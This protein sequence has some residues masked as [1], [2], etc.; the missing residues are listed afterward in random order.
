MFR[1]LA[2]KTIEYYWNTV[3]E[4]N[5]RVCLYKTSCSRFVYAEIEKN[6]FIAG[7]K[8]YIFRVRNCNYQYV[9]NSNNGKIQIQTKHGQL[10]LEE[11]I[12]PIIC[13]EYKSY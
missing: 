3:S 11:E 4:S 6:G 7:V 10:L 1:F 13:K 8:A 12:N 5:R 9:I 2:K